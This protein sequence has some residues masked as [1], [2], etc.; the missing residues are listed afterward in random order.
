MFQVLSTFCIITQFEKKNANEAIV[1]S[2]GVV[3]ILDIR[4]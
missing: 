4:K 1:Y 2:Y 3:F